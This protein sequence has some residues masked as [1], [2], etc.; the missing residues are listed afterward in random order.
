[1]RIAVGQIWQESNT[2]NALRTTRTEIEQFGVLRSQELVEQMACTNELGGFI[3]SLRSWPERPEIVGLVRLG[4]WPGG[5][6]SQETLDWLRQELTEAIA[7]EFPVDAILL[8]L[9]GAMVADGVPDVEG[10]MLQLVRSRIGRAIP[11]V[12]TLDLHANITQ[13]MVQATD[14][15]VLYHTVP[16]LDVFETGCRGAAVL[17]RIL[18][19]GARPTTA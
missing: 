1:M 13:R 9:H 11:P 14:A 5:I 12:V 16:H 19:D 10:E 4:A 8:A 2:F 3:Q 7:R 15:L 17:R 18:I 6:I